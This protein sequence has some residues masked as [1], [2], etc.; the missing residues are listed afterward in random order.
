MLDSCA[1]LLL[2]NFFSRSAYSFL[3]CFILLILIFSYQEWDKTIIPAKT[4]FKF[5]KPYMAL[6]ILFSVY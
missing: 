3:N 6:I 4:T 5:N 1:P 2:I